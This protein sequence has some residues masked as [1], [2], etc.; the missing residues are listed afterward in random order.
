MQHA[1]ECKQCHSE[2]S[3]TDWDLSV[4]PHDASKPENGTRQFKT[5]FCDQCNQ[6]TLESKVSELADRIDQGG[7]PGPLLWGKV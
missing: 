4:V 5:E 3:P 6:Q 7:C 2:W 1:A